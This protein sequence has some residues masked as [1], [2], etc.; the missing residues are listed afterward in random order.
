MAGTGPVNKSSKSYESRAAEEIRSLLYT[1]QIRMP[2]ARLV[3]AVR[4]TLAALLLAAPLVLLAWQHQQLDALQ[5][6]TSR[7]RTARTA[8]SPPRLTPQPPSPP[9]P[10]AAGSAATTLPAQPIID[11]DRN[12]D[13]TTSSAIS[14]TASWTPGFVEGEALGAASKA[15]LCVVMPVRSSNLARAV[16]NARRWSS[17]RGMPCTSGPPAVDLCVFHSQSFSSPRDVTLAAELLQALAQPSQV[18]TP[19]L[20]SGGNGTAAGVTASPIPRSPAACFGAVRF[21]AARIPLAVDVYTIYPTHNFTGPNTHFLRTFD[22]VERLAAVGVARYAAF[23]LMET[24]TFAFRAGWA[25]ALWGTWQRR[26]KEWVMGSRSMCLGPHETEHV[27]GNALYATERTFVRELRREVSRR[28]DSWAFDVLIGHWLL[29]HRPVRIRVSPHILSISTFQRNRTCCEMVQALVATT[30]AT[31]D[32]AGGGGSGGSS[33]VNAAAGDGGAGRAWEGLYLLHTG[34][35]G[36]LRDS[37]VPPSMRSLGLALQDLFVPRSDEQC[38]LE[39]TLAPSLARCYAHTQPWRARLKGQGGD[40]RL[41]TPHPVGLVWVPTLRESQVRGPLLE[42]LRARARSY[43]VHMQLVEHPAL[44]ARGSHHEDGAASS[45]TGAITLA[46]SAS[47]GSARAGGVGGGFGGVGGGGGGQT[48]HHPGGDSAL[49]DPRLL[50][51]SADLS[52]LL[53]KT[54]RAGTGDGQ[55]VA[56]LQPPTAALLH[57]FDAE[58]DATRSAGGAPPELSAWLEGREANPWVHE[59]SACAAA[60]HGTTAGS[61]VARSSALKAPVT[62]AGRVKEPSGDPMASRSS[63]DAASESAGEGGLD[64][65]PTEGLRALEL[66]KTVLQER[67]LVLPMTTNATF[68]GLLTL[69]RFFNWRPEPLGVPDDPWAGGGGGGGNGGSDGGK[70]PG[71]GFDQRATTTPW[72][73]TEGT[74]EGARADQARSAGP[75]DVASL[76]R[77]KTAL[78]GRLYDFAM[79]QFE[80]QHRSIVWANDDESDVCAAAEQAG[81]NLASPR[82]RPISLP[83]DTMAQFTWDG[84]AYRVYQLQLPPPARALQL[85]LRGKSVIGA[86]PFSVNVFISHRTSQPKFSETVLRY[87]FRSQPPHRRPGKF[88]V[89]SDRVWACCTEAAAAAGAADPAMVCRTQPSTLWVAFKLRSKAVSQLSIYATQA[90]GSTRTTGPRTAQ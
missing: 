44:A 86:A 76:L 40:C 21:L 45:T 11:G 1:T 53:S 73:A 10:R 79:R 60:G 72:L 42:W 37:S 56:L 14:S 17:T 70:S 33:S 78:D 31:G 43:G 36:K 58:A 20:R 82:S 13:A 90:S 71:P 6:G 54:G 46:R 18:R 8:P 39:S 57:A 85:L 62:S 87:V 55:L 84:E 64:P 7:R 23:Q 30:E 15:Q 28:L 4:R 83:L 32:G 25:E 2:P 24:D 68:R 29:V 35:I 19:V 49:A 5:Q 61:S 22:M 89:T 12:S 16:R 51:V 65:A 9:P 50:L 66:A 52:S 3:R 47:D 41:I 69:E 81:E 77:R 38:V 26:R 63:W 34:N 75:V 59:L 80:E 67:V 74:T 27:N 88:S 48:V